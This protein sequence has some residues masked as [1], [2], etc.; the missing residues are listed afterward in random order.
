MVSAVCNVWLPLCSGFA[1]SAS[2]LSTALYVFSVQ[3]TGSVLVDFYS[4]AKPLFCMS[5]LQSK[6]KAISRFHLDRILWTSGPL[7]ALQ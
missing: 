4:L 5:T 3:L 7:K 1:L 2:V 6:A